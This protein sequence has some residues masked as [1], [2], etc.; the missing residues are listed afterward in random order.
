MGTG[1]YF[2]SSVSNPYYFSGGAWFLCHPFSRAAA[3]DRHHHHFPTLQREIDGYHNM[4]MDSG[5]PP[6]SQLEVPEAE[7]ILGYTP[8]DLPWEISLSTADFP[9]LMSVSPDISVLLP[10]L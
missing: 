6:S 9:I 2:L 7:G 1:M 4:G 5:S 8:A 3:S 10:V